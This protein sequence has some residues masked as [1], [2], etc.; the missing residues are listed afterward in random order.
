MKVLHKGLPN[1]AANT[2]EPA[3][4]GVKR[5]RFCSVTGMLASNSCLVTHTEY[6]VST[7]MKYCNVHK[8]QEICTESQMLATANCPKDKV[9]KQSVMTAVPSGGILKYMYT[10]SNANFVAAAGKLASQ[11]TPCTIQHTQ[12]PIGATTPT[13]TP[14]AKP[15]A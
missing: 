9:V 6:G 3:S 13:P 5:L 15:T 2:I 1:K 4:I 11:L 12:T 14:T 7:N 8:V 10:A